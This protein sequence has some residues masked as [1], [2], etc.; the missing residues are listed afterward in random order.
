MLYSILVAS[1]CFII[2]LISRDLELTVNPRG[3]ALDLR[4]VSHAYSHKGGKGGGGG[5]GYISLL[6][7]TLIYDK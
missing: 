7:R 2:V 6:D 3:L 4:L 5:G 1:I